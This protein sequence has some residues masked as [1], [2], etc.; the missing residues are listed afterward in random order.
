LSA[1]ECIQ[2]ISCIQ[3]APAEAVGQ[4]ARALG[5]DDEEDAEKAMQAVARDAFDRLEDAANARFEPW[6]GNASMLESP[7]VACNAASRVFLESKP[8]GSVTRDDEEAAEALNSQT[9]AI[10]R[11]LMDASDACMPAGD[12]A[13]RSW[14]PSVLPLIRA[15]IRLLQ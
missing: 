5:L 12:S 1:L 4:A 10:A 11:M 13:S 2:Y 7:G 9:M 8:A 15:I 6:S 14:P 3:A